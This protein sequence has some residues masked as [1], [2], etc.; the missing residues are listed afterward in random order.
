ML[1]FMYQLKVYYLIAVVSL[2]TPG[3]AEAL[4]TEER[5]LAALT[6]PPLAA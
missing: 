5:L 3:V 6:I 1:L 4:S 2:V